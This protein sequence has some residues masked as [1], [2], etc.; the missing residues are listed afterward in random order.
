[1][2]RAI[3]IEKSD[4]GQVVTLRELDDALLVDGDVLVRVAYSTINYKDGLALTGRAPIVRRYPMIP[5]VDLA[6]VVERSDHPAWKPG[7]PV[8]LNGWG[9]GETRWGGLSQ[10]ARL[11]GDLLVPLPPAFTLRQAMALGSAGYTAALCVLALERHGVRPGDGQVLVTGATGGVGSVAVA[12]LARRGHAVV[13]STGKL[14]EAE[15]LRSLGASEVLDRRE[16]AAPG[17][18]LGPARW[19]A[20]V[21]NVGSHTLANACATTRTHGA[22]AAVGNASGMDFPGSVAPFILRGVTLYG[23]DSNTAPRPLRLEAW[24]LLASDLDPRQ[25]EAMTREL[26]LG[27]ATRAAEEIVA[28]RVRGRIVVDVNR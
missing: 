8:I 25:L 15:Y 17:K 19:T 26:A 7:D 10:L 21:D 20:V 11:P 1:M 18:P 23:I 16:L 12:L 28:G 5:G 3:W 14:A 22:V 2:F 6:G 4:A 24:K 27:E 9:S 13:A